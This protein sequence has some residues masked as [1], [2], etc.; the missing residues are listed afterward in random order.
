MAKELEDKMEEVEVMLSELR[1]LTWGYA[2]PSPTVPE[3]IELHR[4]IQDI[5]VRI[6]NIIVHIRS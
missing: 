6:D 3:Y 4:I 2:I 5:L 1:N